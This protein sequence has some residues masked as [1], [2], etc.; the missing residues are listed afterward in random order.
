MITI[1]GTQTINESAGQL[2]T[3]NTVSGPVQ[4]RVFNV[5]S[6]SYGDGKLLTIMGDGTGNSRGRS[7]SA[8]TTTSTSAA[9]SP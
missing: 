2:D 1:N 7:T 9:M 6:Y 3:I 4:F 5:T 8:S